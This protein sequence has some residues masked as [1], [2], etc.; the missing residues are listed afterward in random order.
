MSWNIR[1]VKTSKEE[2]G[3]KFIMKKSKKGKSLL[4]CDTERSEEKRSNR[5]SNL[6]RPW[7]RII[8]YCLLTLEGKWVKKKKR[9]PALKNDC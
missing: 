8:Q 6:K 3:K 4:L 7:D 9:T 5:Y 1:K 2:K